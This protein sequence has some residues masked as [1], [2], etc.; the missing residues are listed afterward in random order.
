MP[1]TLRVPVIGLRYE[2]AAVKFDPLPASVQSKCPTLID[3]ENMRSVFWIYASAQEG[4]RTYY[5]IGG[6]GIRP[7]PEP[8]DFPRY[9]PLDLGTVIQTDDQACKIFGEAREV[10]ETRYLE[11]TPGPIL[12][13]LADNLASRLADA[14][15]GRDNLRA[16]LR[17]QRAQPGRISPEIS[18]AFAPYLRQ[19]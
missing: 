14:F 9:E 7:H 13:K 11:E 18:T 10:F 15:G 6:Y 3:D 19:K 12:Q 4:Q 2:I 17:R 8:P 1:R 5:V 16:E